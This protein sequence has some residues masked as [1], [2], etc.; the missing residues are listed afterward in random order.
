GAALE[1]LSKK[2]AHRTGGP[3]D[4]SAGHAEPRQ[5]DDRRGNTERRRRDQQ[6]PRRGNETRPMPAKRIPRQYHARKAPQH[7][8]GRESAGRLRLAGQTHEERR[9]E[10]RNNSKEVDEAPSERIR[11]AAHEYRHLLFGAETPFAG[12]RYKNN[13]ARMVQN[14]H[15]DEAE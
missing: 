14:Q 9:G 4:D 1:V 13:E 11:E 10:R 7:Q 3:V 2:A 8:I 6:R 5:Y 15:L 12:E